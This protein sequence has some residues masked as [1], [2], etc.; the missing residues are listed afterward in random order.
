MGRETTFVWTHTHSL[1]PVCGMTPMM[2]WTGG[3]KLGLTSRM[4]FRPVLR[5][6]EDMNLGTVLVLE[7]GPEHY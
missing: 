1:R 7:P 5:S 6:P 4:R 2:F 3:N